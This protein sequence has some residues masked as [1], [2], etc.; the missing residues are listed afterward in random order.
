LFCFVAGETPVDQGAAG[1]KTEW[2]DCHETGPNPLDERAHQQAPPLAVEHH[3]S[4]AQQCAG[5]ETGR[6]QNEQT[7]RGSHAVKVPQL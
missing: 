7:G 6:W 1:F 2:Y 5:N 3:G 4:L